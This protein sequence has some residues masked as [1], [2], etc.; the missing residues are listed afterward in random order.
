M[1][2]IVL[3]KLCANCLDTRDRWKTVDCLYYCT[4]PYEANPRKNKT[5]TLD[6][7]FDVPRSDAYDTESRFSSPYFEWK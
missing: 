1:L 7:Q 5:C 6:V 4:C 3:N 2:T